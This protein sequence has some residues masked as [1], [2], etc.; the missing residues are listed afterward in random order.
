[1]IVATVASGGEVVGS[2]I[3]RE[4]KTARGDLEI[5]GS[6]PCRPKVAS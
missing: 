1:M 2:E 6:P 5:G 4:K 3:C